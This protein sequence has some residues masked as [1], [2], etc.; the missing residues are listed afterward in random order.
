MRITSK[1]RL[2]PTRFLGEYDDNDDASALSRGTSCSRLKDSWLLDKRI[3]K[4]KRSLIMSAT[5]V[6]PRDCNLEHTCTHTRIFEANDRDRSLSKLLAIKS[7]MNLR[8][9]CE[10]GII[11]IFRIYFWLIVLENIWLVKKILF[12]A[13]YFRGATYFKHARK[14]R[15]VAIFFIV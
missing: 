1:M 12:L 2:S 11:K 13:T 5:R 9:V 8:C 10:N 7:W 15:F 14:K 6:A 4:E 3:W